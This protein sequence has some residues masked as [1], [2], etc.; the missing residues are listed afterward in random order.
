MIYAI[1]CYVQIFVSWTIWD[2]VI[3]VRFEL[4][5][6]VEF[7]FIWHQ[8]ILNFPNNFQCKALVPYF[9][10]IWAVVSK[11]NHMGLQE[12]TFPIM[13][14]YYSLYAKNKI[15]FPLY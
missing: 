6:E 2:N 10:E 9:I 4:Q 15:K 8:S 3:K 1:F 5:Q 7:I 13:C 12:Q 11:M 14:S